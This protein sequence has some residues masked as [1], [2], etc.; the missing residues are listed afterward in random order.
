M[1]KSV[2]QPRWRNMGISTLKR[3]EQLEN[4]FEGK[5]VLDIGCVVGYRKPNWIHGLIA[6]KASSLVGIDI[7]KD[8]IEEIHQKFPHLD[9]RYGDARN[10]DV[11]DKFDVVHAGE[12]IEHIDNFE[13]FFTSIKRHLKPNG[14]VIITTP[15]KE[16][17]NQFFYNITGGMKV[18]DEHVC[19]FCDKTLKTLVERNG[20]K[21]EEIRFLNQPTVGIRK[22]FRAL[23]GLLPQRLSHGTL[24]VSA[25]LNA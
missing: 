18:N 25:R 14:I 17:I 1:K 19:W 22:V 15:N 21:V 8:A 2:L 10:F 4:I 16:T 20:L 11:N 9:V 24:F 13:G 12:L 6:G 7:D 5:K 23:L 3:F